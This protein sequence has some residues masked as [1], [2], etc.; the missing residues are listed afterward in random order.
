MLCTEQPSV[1]ELAVMLPTGIYAIGVDGMAT[2]TFSSVVSADAAV[3]M[4]AAMET[5]RHSTSRAVKYRFKLRRITLP[6]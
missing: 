3:G 1:L 4:A 6:P 5:Q 2:S